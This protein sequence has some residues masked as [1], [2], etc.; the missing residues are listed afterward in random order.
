MA[1]RTR[2]AGSWIEIAVTD[3]GIGIAKDDIDRLFTEF[4]QL[5]TG[6]GRHQEGTGLGLALTKRFAE[7]H[8]GEVKVQS[9]SGTGSTF[10]L[11]LPVAAKLADPA[12]A[13]RPQLVG[14]DDQSR[15]LIL[16]VET[17]PTPPR[18]SSG[19]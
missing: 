12:P 11:R 16:I 9:V 1:I 13:P 15:P 19:T 17:T 2:Q 7:L 10:I 6:P 4:Q 3:T 18:F 5:D 8:G 14:E